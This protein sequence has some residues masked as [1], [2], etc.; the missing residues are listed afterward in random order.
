MLIR[1]HAILAAALAATVPMTAGAQGTQLAELSIPVP[2]AELPAAPTAA[3]LAGD[4]LPDPSAAAIVASVLAMAPDGSWADLSIAA[5]VQNN[6]GDFVS[7]GGLQAVLLTATD[8]RSLAQVDFAMLPAGGAVRL[9]AVLRVRAD[10]AALPD[11]VLQVAYD[12]DIR[13]DANAANDDCRMTNNVVRMTAA[14][15]R[16]AAFGA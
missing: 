12:A 13:L 8:G 10:D 2:A 16:A 14:E 7:A 6:G 3:A 9:P 15:L 5:L 11:L 4:A 1:A